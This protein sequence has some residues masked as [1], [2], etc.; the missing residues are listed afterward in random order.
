VRAA[1]GYGILLYARG[2]VPL[3]AAALQEAPPDTIMAAN[4]LL[5][6]SCCDP[7][8]AT[9]MHFCC[10]DVSGHTGG[11]SWWQCDFGCG[12]GLDP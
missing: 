6:L 12:G 3:D 9:F 10:G 5:A 8:S 11:V 4:M 7:L 2:E 1:A